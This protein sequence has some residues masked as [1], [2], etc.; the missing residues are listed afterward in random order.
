M[1]KIGKNDGSLGGYINHY[2]SPSTQGLDLFGRKGIVM[3]RFPELNDSSLQRERLGQETGHWPL[4]LNDLI[5]PKAAA[6]PR[7]LET[8]SSY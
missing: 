1:G 7:S 4:R 8:S 5:N 2:K 3:L 6:H